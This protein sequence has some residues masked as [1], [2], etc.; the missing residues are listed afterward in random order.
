VALTEPFTRVSTRILTESTA[1]RTAMSL[2]RVKT[3]LR[4]EAVERIYLS[5]RDLE[6]R[7]S[8]SSRFLIDLRKSF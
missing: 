3:L 6:V 8:I 5:G 7:V 4:S 1:T 2:G